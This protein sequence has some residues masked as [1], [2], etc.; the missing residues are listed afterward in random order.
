LKDSLDPR[1]WNIKT[2]PP[3]V[4][5]MKE[6]PFLGALTDPQRLEPALPKIESALA[7]HG[8]TKPGR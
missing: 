7:T 1:Q 6:D 5:R 2:M 4:A 8:L 3:R